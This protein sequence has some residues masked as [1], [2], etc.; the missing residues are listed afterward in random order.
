MLVP[1][2]VAP[3]ITAQPVSQNV[4]PGG[5]AT[6]RVTA[7]SS[8]PVTYAWQ[9]DGVPISG[10][11]QSSYTTNNVSFTGP[12]K[13]ISC[14]VSNALGSVESSNAT[15]S[16]LSP[17]TSGAI[18]SFSGPKGAI[19]LADWFKTPPVI[20]MAR[21]NTGAT[22][23]KERFSE[24][25]PMA[26]KQLSFHSVAPMA[27]IRWVDGPGARREFIRNHGRNPA[28]K[29]WNRIQDHDQRH[30]HNPFDVQFEQW[31]LPTLDAFIWQRWIFL[32][33]HAVWRSV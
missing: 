32:R 22:S 8:E 26:F 1:K 6:F 29:L 33:N 24:S 17:N 5:S 3:L 14:L 15:L 10:A 28:N 31:R 2:T 20:F 7:F 16:I 25:Q 19:Q 21:P 27:S 13:Q 30:A 11:T 12:A 9:V 4:P 18:Y 23:V